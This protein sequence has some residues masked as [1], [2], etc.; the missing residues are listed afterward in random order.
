LRRNHIKLKTFLTAAEAIE[1]L[2]QRKVDAF[3]YSETTLK[4][5]INHENQSGVEILPEI[6]ESRYFAFALKQDSSLREPLNRALL[7]VTAQPLWRDIQYSYL[8]L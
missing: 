2:S 5:M 1:A 3:V 8:G 4:Y 7:K 6:M